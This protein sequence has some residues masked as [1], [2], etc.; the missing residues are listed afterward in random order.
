MTPEEYKYIAKV[1]KN[2]PKGDILVA[3][4]E[5]GDD[6]R[7]LM[8]VNNSRNIIVIDSFAGLA[9]PTKEDTAEGVDYMK[10]GECNIKGLERYLD[11]FKRKGTAP[12]KEIYQMWITR[13]NLSVI[14]KR[15]IGMMFL[16]LDHYAPTKACLEYFKD[17]MLRPAMIVVHDYGFVRCPGIK[18]C[19]D[20]FATGWKMG[21][22]TGLARLRLE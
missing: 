1:A 14:P 10:E 16:D 12:P 5:R 15:P 3:G 19:C 9:K 7:C 2:F 18:K 20:E 22:K 8:K 21:E 17:W 4:T 13:E 11:T 6:V